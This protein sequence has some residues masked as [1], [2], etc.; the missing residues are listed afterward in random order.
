MK[1]YW[2]RQQEISDF[3]RDRKASRTPTQVHTQD[4]EDTIYSIFILS[5][6]I[7]QGYQTD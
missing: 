4:F 2:R 3:I 5:H 6:V 1:Y 7:T